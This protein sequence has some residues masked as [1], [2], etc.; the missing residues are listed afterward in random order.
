VNTSGDPTSPAPDDIV[1]LPVHRSALPRVCAALN[2]HFVA[3]HSSSSGNDSERSRENKDVVVVPDKI[4][5]ANIWALVV[6][7]HKTDEK[8]KRYG[9]RRAR[10]RKGKRVPRSARRV[11]NTAQTLVANGFAPARRG[12]GDG[13]NLEENPSGAGAS[14][15]GA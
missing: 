11:P 13:E 10:C 3:A 12:R 14:R 8:G 2:D 9:Y 7:D 6:T 4:K 5:D 1:A 15:S